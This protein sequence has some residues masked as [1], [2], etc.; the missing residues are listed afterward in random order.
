MLRALL[1]AETWALVAASQ[2]PCAA[3][4]AGKSVTGCCAGQ[5]AGA[6]VLAEPCALLDAGGAG[7]LAVL[8]ASRVRAPDL[9]P[10][11]IGVSN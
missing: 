10:G 3:L 9:G 7:L 6:L 8:V 5:G 2:H 4:V 11:V 1:A